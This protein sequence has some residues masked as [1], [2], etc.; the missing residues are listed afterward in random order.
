MNA[1]DKLERFLMQAREV[2]AFRPSDR[3]DYP[4]YE[5][6]KFNFQR[7]FP[8]A[9]PQEYERAMGLIAKLTGV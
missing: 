4:G 8:L 3:P 7:D 5:R 9:S 1:P 2:T 6:L